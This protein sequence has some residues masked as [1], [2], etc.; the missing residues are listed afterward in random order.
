MNIEQARAVIITELLN[1]MD[2]KM[3]SFNSKEAFYFSPFRDEKTASLHVNLI[4]NIWYDFGEEKG[5]DGIDLVRYF[6][7]N[8]NLSSEV[9]DALKWMRE[10]SDSITQINPIHQKQKEEIETT[11]NIV[12]ERIRKLND[13]G[14]INY[15]KSRG[16]PVEIATRYVQEVYIRNHKSGAKYCVLGFEN[17]DNGWE[18]RSPFFKGSA[19]P[20][21]ISFIR[22]SI[23]KPD[24]LHIFEG[25]MDFL[26]LLAHHNKK[27]LLA[28]AIVLNSTSCIKGAYPY[29]Y[30]YGYKK[31][32][33]WFD[34]DTSGNRATEKLS[35]Y[36][37]T[38]SGMMH[39][40]MQSH[41]S[42][43]KDLND[44]HMH[45]LGLKQ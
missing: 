9:S 3:D 30:Q 25:F 42:N 37:K 28:D 12:V 20:K 26:S 15:L 16:I 14:L 38:Q 41:Y 2:A 36:I 45:N 7:K 11:P 21:N 35:E 18:F 17:M 5:G 33:S 43:R 34:N 23:V 4:K 10:F 40:N 19:S 22:G 39:H 31:V 32:Y 29:L 24:T 6:L 8:K 1:R 13:Q 44:S 27:Q